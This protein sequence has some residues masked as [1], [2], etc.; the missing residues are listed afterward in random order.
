[1]Q[2]TADLSGRLEPLAESQLATDRFQ[3]RSRR[4]V[5]LYDVKWLAVWAQLAAAAASSSLSQWQLPLSIACKMRGHLQA[6]G[7]QP[8]SEGYPAK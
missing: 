2:T 4:P 6:A 1:M 3:S 5:T 7:A 8:F